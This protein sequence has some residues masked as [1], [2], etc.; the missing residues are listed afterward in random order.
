[1]ETVS[2]WLRHYQPLVSPIDSAARVREWLSVV[3]ADSARQLFELHI[4]Y[5]RASGDEETAR[6]LHHSLDRVLDELGQ[7]PP[8]RLADLAI[9]GSDLLALG[10]RQGPLVG[11][12]LDELHARVLEDPDLND[13]DLLEGMARELIA[14]GGLGAPPPPEDAGDDTKGG[15]R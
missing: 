3:G 5:A 7:G 8:L 13:P 4:A 15:K 12:L 11:L 9:G 14:L 10:V 2:H 1:M 6:Y